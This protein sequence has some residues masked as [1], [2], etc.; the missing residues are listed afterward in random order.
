MLED[1]PVVVVGGDLVKFAEG[2]VLPSE[3]REV[4]RVWADDHMSLSVR[5]D[6]ALLVLVLG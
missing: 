2:R 3:E 5:G 4:M 6:F 1:P